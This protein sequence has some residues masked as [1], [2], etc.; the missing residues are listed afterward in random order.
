MGEVLGKQGVLAI[1]RKDNPYDKEFGI[2]HAF[3]TCLLIWSRMKSAVVHANTCM[4][5]NSLLQVRRVLHNVSIHPS[6][7]YHQ[8]L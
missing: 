4:N 7:H 6:T 1:T 8:Y 5:R 2:S 3:I